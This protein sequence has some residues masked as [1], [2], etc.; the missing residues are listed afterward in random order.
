MDKIKTLFNKLQIDSRS[1]LL[2]IK[3][4]NEKVLKKLKKPSYV[5]DKEF[6]NLFSLL[7]NKDD[8]GKDK[9]VSLPIKA[10]YVGKGDDI[11]RSTLYSFTVPFELLHADIANLEFLGKSAADPKYCLVIVDLFT[12]KTYLY[13][14]KNR[15][16]IALKLEKFYKDVQKKRKNKKTRLQTDLEFK[17]KKI[18]DL[19]R[20][21]NMEMFS[22]VVR[23]GKAFSVEQKI[24][25]LKKGI[26]RLLTLGKNIELKKRPK[27]II[28]KATDNMNLIPTPKCGIPPEIV[29]KISLSSDHCKEWFDIRRVGKISKAIGRYERY[30]TKK[31]LK[32]KKKLRGPLEVGEDVLILSSR[33]KKKDVPGKFYKSSVDNKTFFNRKNIFQITNRKKIENK[34][35][36]WVKNKESK[37][38]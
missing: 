2:T 31:K 6:F 12:S 3:Q 9:K 1:V 27:E 4:L 36:Y 16:L 17:Q 35:F 26:F 29:E 37:K 11:D 21:Y 13:P 34:I 20:K 24:R 23:G 28:A 32:K 5:K 15:K 25:E 8:S 14:M 10:T 22:T 19:N 30:D 18:F 33:I 7:E 38:N